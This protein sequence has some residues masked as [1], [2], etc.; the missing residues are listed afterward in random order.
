MFFL[1]NITGD[2]MVKTLT[3]RDDVYSKLK[4][5]KSREESFSELFERMAKKETQSINEFAGFLSEKTADKMKKN[6]DKRRENKMDL[7]RT[8]RLEKRW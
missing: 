2:F 1:F 5:I 6:L 7:E 8:K 3:I 4:T